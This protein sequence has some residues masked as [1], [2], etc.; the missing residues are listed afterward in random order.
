M[1]SWPAEITNKS[2]GAALYR[3]SVHIP[4][5]GMTIVLLPYQLVEVTP[6][7]TAFD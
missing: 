1:S 6:L 4:V 2:G 5:Q 7:F 3:K